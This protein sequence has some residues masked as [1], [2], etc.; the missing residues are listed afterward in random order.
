MICGKLVITVLILFITLINLISCGN[1]TSVEVINPEMVSVKGGNFQMVGKDNLKKTLLLVIFTLAS[2]KSQNKEYCQY[3]SSRKNSGDN[4]PVLNVSWNDAVAYCK[5]LSDKTGRNYCLP[6]EAEWEYACRAGATKDYYWGDSYNEQTET[7]PNIN[8]YYAWYLENSNNQ[9][10]PVGQK[11]PNKFGLYDMSGNVF[12][13]C[14]DWY[15]NSDSFRVIRGGS[16][17]SIGVF[18]QSGYR[19]YCDKPDLVISASVLSL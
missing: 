6:T 7:C 14:S 4:L 9:F 12:E 2:M 8:D 18:C 10:H 13:W 1:S 11:K 3:D 16:W 19:K 5:W 17:G 15:D